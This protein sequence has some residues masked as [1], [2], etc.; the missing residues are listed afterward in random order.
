MSECEESIRVI[1]N[2]NT[3]KNEIKTLFTLLFDK[4]TSNGTISR[5]AP[6]NA[7]NISTPSFTG[8][9]AQFV[10]IFHLRFD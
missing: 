5:N 2:V 7:G 8:A 6:L 9:V 4:L 10:L 1:L 3:W